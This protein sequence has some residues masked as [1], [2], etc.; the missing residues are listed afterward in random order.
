M[1]PCHCLVFPN[2]SPPSY[3]SIGMYAVEAL[4]NQNSGLGIWKLYLHLYVKD[5]GALPLIVDMGGT[6][7]G[8]NVFL[9]WD[10]D[11]SRKPSSNFFFR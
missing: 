4:Q 2:T 11:E 8:W 5:D 6:G 3:L 10:R 1:A 9:R 7:F